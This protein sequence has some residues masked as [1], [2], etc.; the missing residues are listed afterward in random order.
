[1]LFS[2]EIFFLN[3][4]GFQK[5]FTLGAEFKAAKSA[6]PVLV[7]VAIAFKKTAGAN[8]QD[9]TALLET[10]GESAEKSFKAFAFLSFYFNR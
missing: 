9:F 1:M 3:L 5:I 4:S 8:V 6:I 7:L 10:A 2:S